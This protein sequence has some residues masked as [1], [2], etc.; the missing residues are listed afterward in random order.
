[1]R[2]GSRRTS[3]NLN[4]SEDQLSWKN[5]NLANDK[6]KKHANIL[7]TMQTT[8]V[9]QVLYQHLQQIFTQTAVSSP[10]AQA[11]SLRDA[12]DNVDD[13]ETDTSRII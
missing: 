3:Q 12:V 11:I 1:M 2:K 9:R 7:G 13:R 5:R 8:F 4:A 10:A 6:R